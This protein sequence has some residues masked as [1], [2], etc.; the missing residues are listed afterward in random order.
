MSNKSYVCD[1]H[2]GPVIIQSNKL[3]KSPDL[4]ANDHSLSYLRE[5]QIRSTNGLHTEDFKGDINSSLHSLPGLFRGL[6][7]DMFRYEGCMG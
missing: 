7:E 6:I 3:Y 2:F 5:F 1:A 4:F